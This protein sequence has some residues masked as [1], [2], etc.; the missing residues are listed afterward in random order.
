VRAARLVRRAAP[1]LLLFASAC[2]APPRAQALVL[3]DT[4]APVP[5]LMS[6]LILTVLDENLAPLC[7]GCRRELALDERT[8]WPVSFGVPAP[9]D[10]AARYVRAQLFPVGRTSAGEPQ[11]PTAIDR[12]GRLRF[13]GGVVRQSLALPLDCAG[14]PSDLAAGTT[15]A[16]AAMRAPIDLLP[17]DGGAPSQVGSWHAEVAHPCGGRARGETGLHDEEVCIAGGTFWMGDLRRQGFGGAYDGVPEHAVALSPFFLDRYEWTV[18][19]YRAQLAAGLVPLTAVPARGVGALLRCNFYDDAADDAARDLLPLNCVDA[20]TAEQLCEVDGRRLPS[21]AE[22]EWAAGSREHEWLYPWGDGPPAC[23]DLASVTATTAVPCPDDAALRAYGAP[24][25]IH[26]RDQSV[27]GVFDLSANVIEWVA[28]EFEFYDGPCWLPGGY[29]V[30]PI[31]P[32]SATAPQ[33]GRSIRGGY[34]DDAGPY[35]FMAASRREIEDF[36][37]GY[38]L[39]FRCARDDR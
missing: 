2:S 37:Y 22:W 25:G 11:A 28:D 27:D 34:F 5:R 15:C 35:N 7:E 33:Y 3:V 16:G 17:L 14:V 29:G 30:D 23:G 6:R 38:P 8:A 19:R 36:S 20:L 13:G 12:V 4:D 32:L 26:P 21:E 24:V 1:W 9:P 18:G 39:G 31:C 10:G